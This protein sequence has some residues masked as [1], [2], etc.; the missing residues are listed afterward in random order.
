MQ[1]ERML[2]DGRTKFIMDAASPKEA[3]I[4]LALVDE[5][6]NERACGC[7]KSTEIKFQN[8][9]VTNG[10]YLEMKCMKC[11]AALS[12]G[13]NKEGGG[14]FVKKWD[15]QSKCE[16]PNGGWVV[17]NREAKHHSQPPPRGNE[18][19]QRVNAPPSGEDIPF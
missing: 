9:K 8:R 6:F 5:L 10:S 18:H 4:K 2:P 15:S 19:D 14:I 3:F 16:V 17:Y 1:I 11:G 7:C 12:Y 13:Q